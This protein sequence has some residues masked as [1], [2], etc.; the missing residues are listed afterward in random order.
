MVKNNEST[1]HPKKACLI[2][3]KIPF[4]FFPFAYGYLLQISVCS[5][6]YVALYISLW[7]HF[8]VVRYRKGHMTQDGNTVDVYAAPAAVKSAP[9][10]FVAYLNQPAVL[11]Q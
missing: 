5:K 7:K 2:K 1:A 3:Q 8:E 6:R 4:Y 9:G 11:P 10:L